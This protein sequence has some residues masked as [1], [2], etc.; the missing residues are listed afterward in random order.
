MV[1]YEQLLSDRVKEVKP[2]GIRKYFDA[3]PIC[4]QSR[5]ASESRILKPRGRSAVQAFSL[6]KRGRLSIPG[7]WGL[8]EL[9]SQIAGLTAPQIPAVL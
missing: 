3:V 1:D 7:N 2:S 5:S 6:W 4:R 9:R 8:A